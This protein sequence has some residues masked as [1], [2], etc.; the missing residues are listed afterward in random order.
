[1]TP[2]TRPRTSALLAMNRNPAL[3]SCQAPG[4]SASGAGAVGSGGS[5]GMRVTNHAEMKKDRE[6]SQ[7]AM[8]A[9]R[10][11]RKDQLS[12]SVAVVIA[13]VTANISPPRGNVP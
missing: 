9:G 8:E 12:A 2:V 4:R 1:M 3:S 10:S 13:T 7:I 11:A 6:F 5:E